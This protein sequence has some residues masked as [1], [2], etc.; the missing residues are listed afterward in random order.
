MDDAE[1]VFV[2]YGIS[3]R[4][5]RSAVDELRAEGCKVGLIRPQTLFPFP[6]KALRKALANGAKTFFSVEMSNGQMIDDV[7]LSIDCA[8]PVYLINRMGGN[9]L[10]VEEIVTRTKEMLGGDCK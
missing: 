4:M 9:V 7:K 2:S 10:S 6:E 5:C 3:S 1:Y 8:K